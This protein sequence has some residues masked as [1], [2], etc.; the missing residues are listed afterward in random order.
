M[1]LSIV[2]NTDFK[3]QVLGGSDPMH[4]DVLLGKDTSFDWEDV[5]PNGLSQNGNNVM[6]MHSEMEKRLGL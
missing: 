3:P 1:E 5:Y 4:R 2:E 6:D